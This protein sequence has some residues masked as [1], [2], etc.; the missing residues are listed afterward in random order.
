MADAEKV[1]T[2]EEILSLTNILNGEISRRNSEDREDTV[3]LVI[4][5]VNGNEKIN[6][7]TRLIVLNTIISDQLSYYS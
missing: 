3:Q 1:F 6:P 5:R 2:E 7:Y 4:A